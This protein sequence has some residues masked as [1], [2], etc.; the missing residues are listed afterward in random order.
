MTVAKNIEITSSS[1]VSFEDAVKTGIARASKTI[2]HIKGAWIKD[3]K[4]NI[5]S[6]SITEYRV[7]MI[8]T[9]V[10]ADDD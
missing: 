7:T 4:V 1:T 8:L 5:E 9:F 10:L 3:Q 2:E 6:G